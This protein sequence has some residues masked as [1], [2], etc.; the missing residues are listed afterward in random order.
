M[1]QTERPDERSLVD[2]GAVVQ[3]EVQEVGR[4]AIAGFPGHCKRFEALGYML[5]K[6]FYY[7][8]RL[9]QS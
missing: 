6:G 5:A 2:K 1:A 4:Q 7:S 8:P 9:P 3:D